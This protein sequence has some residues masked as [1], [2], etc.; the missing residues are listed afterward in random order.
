[1]YYS[2]VC[3]KYIPINFESYQC[4][5]MKLRFALGLSSSVQV[6]PN[7]DS[8]SCCGLVVL[9]TLFLLF[10]LFVSSAPHLYFYCSCFCSLSPIDDFT[11]NNTWKIT[12]KQLHNTTGCVENNTF[13]VGIQTNCVCHLYNKQK[14]RQTIGH[15]EYQTW[16]A[17]CVCDS[18]FIKI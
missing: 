8:V 6:Q 3:G 2:H 13:N 5:V 16:L 15:V 12:T 18:S 7:S 17:K 1:M 4:K 11:V 10:F 14:Y 9:W